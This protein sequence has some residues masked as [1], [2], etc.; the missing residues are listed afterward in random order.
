LYRVWCAAAKPL[1]CPYLQGRFTCETHLDEDWLTAKGRDRFHPDSLVRLSIASACM[2]AGIYTYR[3]GSRR[4]IGSVLQFGELMEYAW[5][6][7]HAGRE[8]T[9]NWL[10]LPLGE[11]ARMTEHLGPDF[12]PPAT[13]DKDWTVKASDAG[14]RV[15]GP[16][17][18][19]SE[20]RQ[21]VEANIVSI[22]SAVHGPLRRL[23]GGRSAMLLSTETR[24]ALEPDKEYCVEF[25]ISADPQYD[26]REGTRF[27]DVLRAVGVALHAD[28]HS[29]TE[30]WI[31]VGN[32]GRDVALTLRPRKRQP[33]HVAFLVGHE[34]G[35]VRVA[36]LRLREGCAE[37]LCRQFERGLALANGSA[38]SPYTF[39]LA[40]IGG[41]RRYRRFLGAQAPDVNTGQSVGPRVTVPALD[42]LLLRSE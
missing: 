13:S 7:Y 19:S 6:E 3:A 33:Y 27:A 32:K 36:D 9:H 34:L 28:D 31:L 17:V 8:G 12:L 5:D 15:E 26:E 4:D 39:N 14:I 35:P 16:K 22:E 24:Q 30:Q 18:V 20:G 10:G 37:V 2:G 25:W 29:S 38:V 40:K 11:P 1:S 23:D 21:F 42:G 41:G